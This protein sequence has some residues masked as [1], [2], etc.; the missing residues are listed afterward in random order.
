MESP[1]IASVKQKGLIF[2]LSAFLIAPLL[3]VLSPATAA[4]P[5]IQQRAATAQQPPARAKLNALR[6]T[7]SRKFPEENIA[8][9]TG[10]R[11]GDMIGKEEIQA[12]A[13]RLARLGTFQNVRYRFTGR[14]ES[15]DVEITLEDSPTVPVMFD[16]FPLFSDG[17]L[18]QALKDAAGLFDGTAPENGTIL[19]T[20]TEALQQLLEKRGVEATVERTLLAGPGEMN[21]I[22]RFQMVGVAGLKVS[23]VQFGDA[24]AAESRRLAEPQRDL[25]GKPYSRFVAAVFANEQVRPLY[26]E[27][28]FLRVQFGPAQARFTGDPRRPLPETVTLV[29]PITPGPA[30]RWGGATW[31]GNAVFPADTLNQFLGFAADETV[32][33]MKIIAGWERVRSEYGRRGY[34]DAVVEPQAIYD[35]AAPRVRYAV[36]IAEGPQY[37]MGQLT[38]TGLSLTA[39]RMIIA[40]WRIPAGEVFDRVYFE[41]FLEEQAR[42]KKAFGEYVVHF[43]LVGPMLRTNPDKKTVDVFLDFQ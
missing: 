11:L 38:I 1:R 30:Y 14:E 29:L 8:A 22:Q 26:L 18:T 24:L 42:K 21:M 28:G 16:N 39:E 15:V 32:N 17:E 5:L 25:I 23:A 36:K 2:C 43:K 31:S 10:L 40:A 35:D 12:A 19:D 41:D 20:M 9:L 27:K 34:L 3:G 6:I 7:G 37:R 4:P 13:D 33:G